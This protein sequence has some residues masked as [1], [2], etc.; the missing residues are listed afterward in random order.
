MTAAAHLLQ[1]KN[2]SLFLPKERMYIIRKWGKCLR[3]MLYM[4]LICRTH[5]KKTLRGNHWYIVMQKCMRF[6]ENVPGSCLVLGKNYLRSCIILG[7]GLCMCPQVP[8]AF[9]SEVSAVGHSQKC[10]IELGGPFAWCSTVAIWQQSN[11]KEEIL[12]SFEDGWKL[13]ALHAPLL[14]CVFPGIVLIPAVL[15]CLG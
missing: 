9:Y 12:L 14:L 13:I 8:H 5:P 1:V 10:N 7:R 6:L 2:T 3:A 4:Q 11:L 15:N